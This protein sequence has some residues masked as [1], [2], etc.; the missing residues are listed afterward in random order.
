MPSLRSFIKISS[1]K[2][3]DPTKTHECHGNVKD[4][5]IVGS[6]GV[7]VADVFEVLHDLNDWSLLYSFGK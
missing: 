4:L 6:D 2:E 1:A 3:I 5:S 7:A